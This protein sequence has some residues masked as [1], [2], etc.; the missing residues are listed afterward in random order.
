MITV[1]G[2]GK[3]TSQV[4]GITR[5]LRV[6]WALEEC[7]LAYQFHGLDD[8]A[9]DLQSA[10][11]LKLNPFGKVPAI[12]HNGFIIFESGAILAYLAEQ[13]GLL[14]PAHAA[15]RATAL[16][17][18]FAALDTVEQPLTEIAII[19]LFEANAEWA[20]Q[21]RPGF[22]KQAYSRLKVL[23]RVL[24]EKVYLLGEHFSYPDILM[25]TTLHQI[26]HTDILQAFSNVVSYLARCEERPAWRQCLHTYKQRLAGQPSIANH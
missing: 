24:N 21:R 1:Y 14:M 19:D 10:E 11:Y 4:I 20:K 7:D 17:W 8:F 25:A 18:A 12:D 22:V 2:F 23:D 26:Q 6:L 13:S 5:D 3:V 9:G 16:Q 15:G